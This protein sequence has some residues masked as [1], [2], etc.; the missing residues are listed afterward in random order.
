M[1]VSLLF[2]CHWLTTYLD[3]RFHTYTE[4]IDE[5]SERSEDERLHEYLNLGMHTTESALSCVCRSSTRRVIYFLINRLFRFAR[6]MALADNQRQLPAANNRIRECACSSYQQNTFRRSLTLTRVRPLCR[7]N[8]IPITNFPPIESIS[9]CV[10]YLYADE[11]L[12]DDDES[13]TSY[14]YPYHVCHAHQ[15]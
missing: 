7:A 9:F 12:D 4:T 14:A 13:H 8:K 10:L 11:P 6:L 1:H 2:R 5:R 15:L 3:F